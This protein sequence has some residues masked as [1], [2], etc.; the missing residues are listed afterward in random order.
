MP[1]HSPDPPSEF[2]PVFGA[3]QRMADDIRASQRAL[4]EA[5]RRTAAVLA[6][7]ATGVVALDPAGRVLLAN[8]R[9]RELLG[10]ELPEDALLLEALGPAWA[11]LRDVVERFLAAGIVGEV[12]AELSVAGRRLTVQLAAA[13]PDLAGVVLALND[14]TDVSRAE[15]VLAWGEMARQVAHEIKNPLTPMRLGMQHLR[16]AYRAEEP[17]AEFARTLEETSERVLGEI[18]RLDTIA[19]AFS[20]FGAPVDEQEPLAPVDAAAVAREVVQ[21][22]GLSEDGARVRL[23]APAPVMAQLRRDELKE[24][25]VN[26]LE[27]ARDAG[28]RD[29]MVRAGAGCLSVTDDGRG[30]APE[31]LPRI[32]EPRFS[33]TTS[34][35]GLGLAIVRRLV[36]SWAGR[37]EVASEVGRG[38]VVTIHLPEQGR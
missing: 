38:T 22:Y 19:R 4:E 12:G 13:G 23:D 15:R 33:T 5:R 34:G 24:V 25:L 8:P 20:R 37:V 27:N 18:D 11:E 1:L 28:A 21:L 3:F 36:E 32:F 29:V 9:A 2:A 14:V 26:L 16:R 31:L 17:R 30:I 6:T 35:S 7:A 10:V